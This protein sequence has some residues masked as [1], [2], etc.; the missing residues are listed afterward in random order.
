[1][2]LRAASRSNSSRLSGGRNGA[3][4]RGLTAEV[5]RAED[6]NLIPIR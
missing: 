1:M 4:R 6:K 5:I 2:G 3:Q